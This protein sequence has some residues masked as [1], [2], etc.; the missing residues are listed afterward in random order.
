MKRQSGVMTTSE[1]RSHAD[2]RGYIIWFKRK[3]FCIIIEA[4]L[5]DPK[6]ARIFIM[7]IRSCIPGPSRCDGHQMTGIF[8]K[9]LHSNITFINRAQLNVR[10]CA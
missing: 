8:V 2:G 7:G 6:T 9:S 4:K 10:V 3:Q 5:A 1:Q